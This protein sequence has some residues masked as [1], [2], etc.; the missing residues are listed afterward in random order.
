MGLVHGFNY[1][2]LTDY[3]SNNQISPEQLSGSKIIVSSFEVRLPFTGPER[4][5]VIKSQ[6]L[7]SELAWFIDGGVAFTDYRDLGDYLDPSVKPKLVFSTG[8]SA[9]I[10]LFGA[11]VVEPYY[12]FPLLKDAKPRFGVFLVP[13][14]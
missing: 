9:R 14:W 6:A 2:S 3:Q 8:V 11:M 1:G 10:N 4:L 12:A 7:Y 5:A 13:G